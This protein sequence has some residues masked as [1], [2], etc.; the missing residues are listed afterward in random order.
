MGNE[1]ESAR[2][3]Q[4]ESCSIE[5]ETAS[6]SGSELSVNS[7]S[8]SQSSGEKESDFECDSSERN[9]YDPK[10]DSFA[11]TMSI[12]DLESQSKASIDS[13]NL[14]TDS[15]DYAVDAESTTENES[16]EASSEDSN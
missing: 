3:T 9:S 10:E 8:E 16:D 6:A 1:S 5:K 12:G 13:Y 14:S 7:R 15:F 11:Y 4:S 2:S